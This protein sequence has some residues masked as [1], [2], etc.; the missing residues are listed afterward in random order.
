MTTLFE[1]YRL[2]ELL[3]P[4]RVVMAPM[5]RVRAA[6]G[7]LATPSMATYY[8]QRATAGL[9]V[10]EGVQPSLIGQANP[11]TPG[12]YDDAQVASW[13]PVTAAVH[14]NGG[15]VFAQI[16]HG[17]RVG[18][19]D[20]T[21]M[22]PVG[23]SA[24]AAT[25]EVFTPTSPQPA[26][27][28][29]ALETAE[30]PEHA[31][32]YAE[33]A[34]RAVEAGFDGVELHGANGYLISQFL[35]SA[36]NLRTDRYGGSVANRIRF[37]VEATAATVD[38][39]GAARTGIRLSPGGTF[40]GAEESDVPELYAALLDE[41]AGL[42]LAYVHLEATSPDEVLTGLRRAWPGT[43]IMNPVLPLGPKQTDRAAADRWLGLG[44]DLISFGR[45]FIANPDLV[46]RL[47]TGVPIAPVDEATYFQ[48][49]DAGYL[50]YPA[51]VHTA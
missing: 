25:G 5:S 50:T 48:G 11:G 31:R 34:R 43:L 30:V 37:A 35:S 24:V 14:A 10:S 19:P 39:I 8:A 27:V 18:H 46:E 29:R 13:R 1:Q 40:W 23:P 12:L 38:A 17:G 22:L 45:A 2:G 20:T 9:I 28:P 7:G 21:G 26:P 6:A 4:N 47:R 33:A 36:A 41:L 15:R 51:Y 42:G 3:L 44:A 16:M 49:G 32:S